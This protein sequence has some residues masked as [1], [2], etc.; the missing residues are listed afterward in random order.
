MYFV[1]R[2]TVYH[3]K[4]KITVSGSGLKTPVSSFGVVN[5]VEVEKERFDSYTLIRGGQQEHA[6]TV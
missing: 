6:I 2:N 3:I 4:I 1:E 5:H